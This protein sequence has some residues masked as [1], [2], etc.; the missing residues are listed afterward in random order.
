MSDN[1]LYQ[2]RYFK[3][4][5]KKWSEWF[6]HGEKLE[7]DGCVLHWLQNHPTVPVQTRDLRTV[8]VSGSLT[9]ADLFPDGDGDWGGTRDHG[10]D[11]ADQIEVAAY[12]LRW[13]NQSWAYQLVRCADHIIEL[14]NAAE[15]VLLAQHSSALDELRTALVPFRSK[16]PAHEA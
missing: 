14:T 12:H 2:Y 4:H 8:S 3:T 9:Q 5:A 6:S 7:R 16:V 10:N 11:V 15:R 1:G 13:S